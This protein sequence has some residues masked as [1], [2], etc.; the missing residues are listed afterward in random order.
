LKGRGRP[1]MTDQDRARVLSALACVDAVVIFDDLSPERPLDQLR[2][3]VWVKGG[4]YSEAD[5]P[6]ADV[7]RRHGGEVVLLPTVAGYSSSNLIAAARS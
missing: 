5:L 6:E 7:V 3:D 1:V 2:P 4:D